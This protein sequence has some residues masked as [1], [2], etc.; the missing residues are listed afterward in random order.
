MDVIWRVKDGMQS[1]G[2]RRQS[3]KRVQTRPTWGKLRTRALALT[4]IGSPGCRWA[5]EK[6]LEVSGVQTRVSCTCMGCRGG[7]C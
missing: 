2:G 4:H 1:N 3:A 6:A 7:Y 5:S